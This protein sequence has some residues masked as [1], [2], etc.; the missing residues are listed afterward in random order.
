MG[1]EQFLE[2]PVKN[3]DVEQTS[4][5]RAP[6]QRELTSI[7]ADVAHVV[8]T[9]PCFLYGLLPLVYPT[10]VLKAWRTEIL[11]FCLLYHA[12]VLFTVTRQICPFSAKAAKAFV[13]NLP[14]VIPLSPHGHTYCHT[15]YYW[16]SI[17]HSLFHSKLK[18]FLFCKSSLP[19]PFLFLIQVSL[20]GFP[21]LFTL[22]LSI[23]VFLH[24]SFSVFTLFSCRFRAVD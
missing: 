9:S 22:L 15:Y 1:K 16:Y 6:C 17:T 10:P 18:S 3:G 5:R 12:K 21:R 7:P 23:S 14:T 4:I 19:Q 2:G 13:Q 11:K 8:L 24:F 20:Y